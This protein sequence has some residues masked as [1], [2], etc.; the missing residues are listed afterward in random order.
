MPARI[1]YLSV[2]GWPGALVLDRLLACPQ[3]QVVGLVRSNRVL[4]KNHSWLSGALAQLKRSGL[5]YGLY[6]ETMTG[7]ADLLLA[8]SPTGSFASRAKQAG[9]PV[10]TSKDINS[11]EALQFLRDLEPDL[12]L[13]GFF[14]QRIGAAALT[15]PGKAAVNI[16]PSLLPEFKGVDPM[17]FARLR[18]AERLGVSLHHLAEDFDAGNLLDQAELTVDP[19]RSVLADTALAFR[20]G[21]ELL[22]ENLEQ[23]L[24]GEPGRPQPS[25][26]SYDSWPSPEQV[27]E[28]RGKGLLLQA[29]IDLSAMRQGC[30]LAD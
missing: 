25:G 29:G 11:P 15:I 8:G 12:L 18:G 28:L 30:Q 19:K 26:G 20:R 22:V 14:N 13:S 1:V 2:G 4:S 27:E 24:A 3:I 7:L 17:F 5:R 9:I 6:L 23:V 16:H 10:L 21:A